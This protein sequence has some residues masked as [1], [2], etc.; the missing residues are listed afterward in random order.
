M[1]GPPRAAESE[2]DERHKNIAYAVQDYCERAMMSV[3]R[4]ALAQN[5][6]A[7]IFAL[8]EE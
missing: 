4:L 7:A 1:L 8:Q 5:E 6:V 2:I 3:V